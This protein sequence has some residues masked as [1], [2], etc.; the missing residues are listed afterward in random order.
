MH[1][2]AWLLPPE[3]VEQGRRQRPPAVVPKAAGGYAPTSQEPIPSDDLFEVRA[4]HVTA[5]D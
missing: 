2:S 1:G 4:L 5:L 3:L